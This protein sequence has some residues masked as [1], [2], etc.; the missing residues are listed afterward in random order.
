MQAVHKKKNFFDSMHILSFK[1]YDGCM[2][3][4]HVSVD[5]LDYAAVFY[6]V[7]KRLLIK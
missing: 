2:K 1:A 4:K 5:F 3:I 7:L 6:S